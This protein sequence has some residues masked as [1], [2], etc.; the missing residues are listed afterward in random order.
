MLVVSTPKRPGWTVLT[1]RSPKAYSLGGNMILAT[2]IMRIVG[3]VAPPELTLPS[4]E[5][6]YILPWSLAKLMTPRDSIELS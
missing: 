5:Q 4:C 3:N 2:G 6:R 1:R